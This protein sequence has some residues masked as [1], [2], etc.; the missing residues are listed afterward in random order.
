M[1]PEVLLSILHGYNSSDSSEA[2]DSSTEIA[3]RRDTRRNELNSNNRADDPVEGNAYNYDSVTTVLN[4]QNL[5]SE[6]ALF[7]PDPSPPSPPSPPRPENVVR[8][9]P[10]LE[11]ARGRPAW[12]RP[13]VYRGTTFNIPLYNPSAPR[14]NGFDVLPSDWHQASSDDDEYS[15]DEDDDRLRDY[16]NYLD[17]EGDRDDISV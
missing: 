1:L 4:N 13:I 6:I 16:L 11:Q 9:S 15:D 17:R 12:Y 7:V 2:A 8:R 5:L 14:E 10:R 3:P